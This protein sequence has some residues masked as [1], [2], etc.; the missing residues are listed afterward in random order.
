MANTISATSSAAAK[1]AEID[2]QIRKLAPSFQTAITTTIDAESVPLKKVQAESAALDIRRAIYT[3]MKSNFDSLKGFVEVLMSSKN[4][5]GLSLLP[6]ISITPN[7]DGTSLFGATAKDSTLN[8]EYD[9]AVTDLAKAQT[10]T[11][12]SGVTSADTVLG[13]S[14]TIY[15][16]GNGENSSVSGFSAGTSVTAALVTGTLAT[17]QREL[18]GGSYSV[19]VR[20]NNGIRQFRLLNGDD[21]AV[22]ILK[23]DGSSATSDWQT[24][25]TGVY[26]TGRGLKLALSTDG[27]VGSTALTYTAKGTSI[28]VSATD[29]LRTIA[30]AINSATQPD[31]R[32]FKATIVA[33][34]LVLSGAQSGS[35][36]SL[37][38]TDGGGLLGSATILQAAQNSSFTVNNIAVSRA[39]N[40]GLSDVIDGVTLSL[41]AKSTADK[42]A[43]LSIA[44]NS[45]KAAMAITNL[46]G[47]F[48]NGLTQLTN[49]MAITSK[50]DSTTGK[51]NYTRGALS[52]E[53][54]FSS[55]RSE[56][57]S[58]VGRGYANSGSYKSLSEIGLTLDKN[59]QMV[60]DSAKFTTALQNHSS[61][62]TALLET[63]MGQLSNTLGTYTGTSG[64]LQRKMDSIDSQKK[65]YDQRIAQHTVSL[66]T[67][68]ETLYNNY[69]SMQS[70]LVELNYQSGM[71][72]LMMYGVTPS[73]TGT[74]VNTSG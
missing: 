60:F 13:K 37:L 7:S 43:H 4:A 1:A 23:A 21:S 20:D 58:R 59:Q 30:A 56:L 11:F 17:G 32:D 52:G 6:K 2:A 8:G 61:D 3:D 63:A 48:N 47:S 62:V 27:A 15:L 72:N 66:T 31:G 16:G 74:T 26:D 39:T 9:I 29:T 24:M 42:P 22:S 36:H 44:S 67:R 73:S 64:A 51:T 28:A 65:S 71:F 57:Y 45:E 41:V 25:T 49:K 10:T 68:K 5:S 12:A 53:T 70:Q 54:V 38:Y 40:S 34:K 69:L 46:V 14:G 35:N 50:I 18:G 19:E 55:L 33:N